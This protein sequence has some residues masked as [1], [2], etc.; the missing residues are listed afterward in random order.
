M[1]SFSVPPPWIR[2]YKNGNKTTMPWSYCERMHDSSGLHISYVSLE[3][4][5]HDIAHNTKRPRLNYA[6]TQ[7]DHCC[8]CT[9]VL[10]K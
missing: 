2:R 3:R 4:Q 9:L 10:T 5:A 8:H 7:T 1:F 6:S